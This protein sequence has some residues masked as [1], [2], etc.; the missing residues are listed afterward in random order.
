MVAEAEDGVAYVAGTLRS[1]DVGGSMERGGGICGIKFWRSWG[2]Y[3]VDIAA[4][5][6][7]FR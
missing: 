5:W 6:G 3:M 2:R 4:S 7:F 1:M